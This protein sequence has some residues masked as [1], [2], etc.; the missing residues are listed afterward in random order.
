MDVADKHQPTNPP[1]TTAKSAIITIRNQV[2]VLQRLLASFESRGIDL[3]GIK[4]L[5]SKSLVDG[6]DFFLEFKLPESVSMDDLFADLSQ[7]AASVTFLS[8]DNVVS[9][10]E[11]PWFP[12]KIGDLDG[13]AEKTLE[14]GEE[15]DADHPGFSDETY[16]KRRTFIVERAKT[17]RTGQPLP[18]IEY[19]EQEINTWRTI[20]TTLKSLWATNACREHNHVFPLLETNC[21]FS[22]NKIPQLQEVSKF[23]EESTGWTL[24][25][26][27]GLLSSRDFLNAFA[28]R[29]FHS[30]QYIRHHSKPMYT[31]EP[32]VCHELLGHIP[33]FADPAFADFSHEIGLA[34]LGASDEEI[35]KL[36][37]CY[38]FTVEFGLCRQDGE[39]KAYGAGLL[40]SFGELEYCLSGKPQLK[41][42]DPF[43]TG[44][45]KY[46]ITE[47]QPVYYVAESFEKAK[48]QMRQYA[49]SMSR[50]FSVKY[51]A[52][53]RSVEVLDTKD[54][55]IKLVADI[56]S[57]AALAAAALRQI[58]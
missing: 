52:Y 37:T 7:Q 6:Y 33:L 19:T 39:T 27:M 45:A 57:E 3:S 21:G 16:R 10:A 22:P 5:P 13:F 34:S 23:L 51:N 55:I 58:N 47:Y 56:Q 25:P 29:V 28:F 15:L 2:G 24:R 32:D 30:T 36:A 11:T 49:Q 42:F 35:E 8:K 41:P 14:F 38:W 46:P 4:S 31:P 26:V 9:E 18:T 1:Q 50:P 54:K 53:T 43:Q 40:S 48:A 20:Y 17:H 44:E 12:R